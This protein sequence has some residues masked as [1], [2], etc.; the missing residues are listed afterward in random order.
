MCIIT[1][2]N[3]SRNVIQVKLFPEIDN[4]LSN[5]FNENQF[6]FILSSLLLK[7]LKVQKLK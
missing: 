3:V 4:S 1:R 6:L 5:T 7:C 2:D